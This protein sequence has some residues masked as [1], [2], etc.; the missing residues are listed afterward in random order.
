MANV[1]PGEPLAEVEA[2]VRKAIRTI[3]SS[4]VPEL[5]NRFGDNIVVFGFIRP[6]TAARIFERRCATSSAGCTTS[7]G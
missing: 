6:D 1:H 4:A 7:T 2:R 3:S 5:L